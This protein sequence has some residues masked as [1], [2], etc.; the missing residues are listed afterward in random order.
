MIPACQHMAQKLDKQTVLRKAVQHLKA[1]KG[2][3]ATR[4]Q[5]RLSDICS[6]TLKRFVSVIV[7]GTGSAFTHTTHKPS[8][9]PNDELRH[10]LLRVGSPPLPQRALVD[11]P[12]FNLSVCLST[13]LQRVSCWLLVVTERKSSSSPSP[14]PRSSPSVRCVSSKE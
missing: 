12:S 10:L 1:L 11:Y 13:R 4:S 5:K 3:L 14:L 9:L 6:H 8:I 2:N 7:A